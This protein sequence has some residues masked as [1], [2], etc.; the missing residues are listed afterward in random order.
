MDR[1]PLRLAVERGFD[2]IV[3]K[4]IGQGVDINTPTVCGCCSGGICAV[5]MVL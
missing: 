2:R 3:D 1:I 4:L 5:G